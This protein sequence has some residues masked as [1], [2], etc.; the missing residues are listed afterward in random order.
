MKTP[1]PEEIVE[2]LQPEPEPEK[3]ELLPSALTKLWRLKTALS[4]MSLKYSVKRDQSIAE[5]NTSKDYYTN[6]LPG[7]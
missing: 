6:D 1:V 7:I 5:N 2:P 4:F 3:L